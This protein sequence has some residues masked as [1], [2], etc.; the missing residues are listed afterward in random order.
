MNLG[1]IRCSLWGR[2]ENAII[3]MI[4]RW[5]PVTSSLRRNH[6]HRHNHWHSSYE[7]ACKMEK[8]QCDRVPLTHQ[9]EWWFRPDEL[10]EDTPIQNVIEKLSGLR[11][12]RWCAR[13]TKNI[14]KI[15]LNTSLMKFGLY[16]S[17]SSVTG[18]SSYFFFH[19][20]FL[21]CSGC[22]GCRR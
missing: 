8:L 17:P 1:S 11:D 18:F 15:N 13:P 7:S 12:N 10:D 20:R 3:V 2:R 5:H 6:R 9:W 16:G 4:F 14:I 22:S 19:F 21:F